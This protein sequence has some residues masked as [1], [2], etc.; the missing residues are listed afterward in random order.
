MQFRIVTL[1]T[2][3][4]R[5]EITRTDLMTMIKIV[6]T[7]CLAFITKVFLSEIDICLNLS[8]MKSLCKAGQA[9]HLFLTLSRDFVNKTFFSCTLLAGTLVV[10]FFKSFA[11]ELMSP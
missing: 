4:T 8:H 7:Q 9:G 1:A 5:W 2:D 3:W 10:I 6:E 11:L